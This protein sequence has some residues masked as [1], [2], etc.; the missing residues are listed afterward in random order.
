MIFALHGVFALLLLGAVS[1]HAAAKTCNVAPLGHGKDDTDQ[2]EAAIARCGHFGTTVFAPG[3]YNITR[4]MT[5]DLVSSRVDLHGYLSFIPDIQYW[6]DA[7]NTYR[8][9]FIQDQASWFVV[10][11]RDFVIDAHSTGGI[12]GNGQPWWSYF[13]TRT[14]E[15]GDGRPVAFTLKNVTRGVV[16]DFRIEAQPFWCNAV[17]DSSEVVYDGMYCN[18]TNQDPLYAGQ[19]VVPNT[20]GIDTYRSD[21]ITL[22]RWDITCGDDCLAIKGNS[23]NIIAKDIT[24]RGGNGIAFGSLGQY[25][26]FN[27]IV[28]HVLMEDLKLIRLDPQVQPNLGSGVYFKSWTGTV[29]GSPP[30][31]GGG[32]G[33]YVSNVV[34]KDVSLDNVTLPIHVYQTNGGHTGDEPSKLQFSNLTF[35]NWTGTSQRSTIVEL[36]CSPA[37][38]CPNMRFENIN[39][40]PPSGTAPSYICVNVASEFGLPACNATGLA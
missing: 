34:V 37:A 17:A 8:V 21:K 9:I 30:T 33:G 20:D 39:I 4:K 7:H 14:R 35:V 28:D 31:G 11:G 5:W 24:C 18:A 25:V 12:N 38:P 22:L 19:N 40:T 15:D 2:V 23:T 26:Q 27:D 3:E 16:R 1:G 29:N 36:A 10:T 13:A 6:L 32:G